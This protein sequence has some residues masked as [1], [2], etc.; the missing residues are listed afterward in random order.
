MQGQLIPIAEV[1]QMLRIHSRAKWY[2][3]L[4]QHGIQVV[5]YENQDYLSAED[6]QVLQKMQQVYKPFADVIGEQNLDLTVAEQAR[7]AKF[8]EQIGLAV[9]SE[10]LPFTD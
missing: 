1:M 3:R 9:R 10:T 2:K 6:V 8:L 5:E 4:E 7:T